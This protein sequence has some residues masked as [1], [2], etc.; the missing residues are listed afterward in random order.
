MGRKYQANDGI[1]TMT[2]SIPK[3][4][5][6]NIEL[7]KDC[8][9]LS[10][11]F[12]RNLKY[13]PIIDTIL[14][15]LVQN[16]NMYLGTYEKVSEELGISYSTVVR[17]F[18]ALLDHN[19]LERVNKGIYRVNATFLETPVNMLQIKYTREGKAKKNHGNE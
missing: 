7:I 18:K 10:G 14:N 12:E 19:I 13:M 3:G 1:V 9:A 8:I 6:I 4:T 5:D 11:A 16:T 15:N 17:T 2:K